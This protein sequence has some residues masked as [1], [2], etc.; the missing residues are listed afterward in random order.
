MRISQPMAHVHMHALPSYMPSAMIVRSRRK[1]AQR[2]RSSTRPNAGYASSCRPALLTTTTSINPIVST[3]RCRLRPFTR[4]P[5]RQ[6]HV[7]PFFRRLHRLAVDDGG[8]RIGMPARVLA[9][10]AAQSLVDQQP[11]AVG[12]KAIVIMSTGAPVGKVM[13]D[14]SPRTA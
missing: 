10:A 12:A 11:G 8:G 5:A 3:A 4:L 1:P 6:N 2:K 7:S 9:H 13:G 14:R